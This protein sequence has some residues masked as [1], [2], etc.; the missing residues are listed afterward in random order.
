MQWQTLKHQYEARGFTLSPVNT[1]AKENSRDGQIVQVVANSKAVRPGS[2][3]V[4]LQGSHVDAHQF[5]PQALEASA[6]AIIVQ[7]SRV[8]QHQTVAWEQTDIPVY[9]ALDS[10]QA[11]AFF[12][13]LLAGM[14]GESMTLVGVTGTNGKTTVTHL[15]ESLLGEAG[16]AVGLIGTLGARTAKA[17]DSYASTGHTTPMANDLQAKLYEMKKMGLDHVVL[18]VSSHALAQHRVAG[19]EFKVAVH[20]NLTQDHLDFHPTMQD[21]F[22]AKALLFRHLKPGAVAIINQDDE[23]GQQFSDAVPQGVPIWHYGFSDT[24]NPS[25]DYVFAKDVTYS[26][27]G[28]TFTALTSKGEFPVRLKMAGQFSVYNS[29]AALAAGLAMGIPTEACVTAL[30][31]ADGVRGRFEVVSEKPYVIVDYAHTPDGLENIFEA[32]RKVLP[33]GGRLI[34]VFGCGG[35]RDATKRPKMGAIV[36]KLADCVVVTSDNPR[37]E[38]PQQIIADI[39]AGIPRFDAEKHRVEADRR[40]AIRLAID[41]SQPQDVI[42]VAGKGHEDYQILADR[43]IHFDDKEEVQAYIKERDG[44]A[45]SSA[46]A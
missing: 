24:P 27:T 41:W 1:A 28:A 10:Y 46:S 12:N 22:E 32:A 11:F 34:G 9:A 2:V 29:L 18:E 33:E 30:E 20:T 14:P 43:V 26:I 3:F 37:T 31:K 45:V 38:D 40:A 8:A 19:C 42:V 17:G 5:V 15:I 36:D 7:Q 23:W 35:D 21:Y 25:G 39:L 4:A 6:S 13:A 44:S 16:K